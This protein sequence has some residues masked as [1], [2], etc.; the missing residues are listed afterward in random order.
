M[1]LWR[2]LLTRLSEHYITIE[3]VQFTFS[4]TVNNH[5]DSLILTIVQLV[6]ITI[7]T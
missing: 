1:F 7:I 3:C 2:L 5:A 6:M 4:L